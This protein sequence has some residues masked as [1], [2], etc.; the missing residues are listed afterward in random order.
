MKTGGVATTDSSGSQSH[1]NR[2]RSWS[3]NTASSPSRTSVEG[4]SCANAARDVRVAA[5]VLDPVPAHEADAG[6]VLVGQHAVAVDLLLVD[7]AV[8]TEGRADEP[9]GEYWRITVVI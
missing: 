2:D 5:G 9:I 3:S 6:A 8:A 1:S 7:P 4:L